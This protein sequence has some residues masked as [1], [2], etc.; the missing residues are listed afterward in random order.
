MDMLFS[1]IS[2]EDVSLTNDIEDFRCV[3]L[4]Y[5]PVGP[6]VVIHVGSVAEVA[7]IKDLGDLLDDLFLIITTE[8]DEPE[9][10]MRCRQLYPRL[11]G[12]FDEDL[13]IVTAVIEKRLASPV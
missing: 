4:E 8:N 2:A 5:R 3:L 6:I 12:Y 7:E 1:V 13:A 11:L 9:V 10:L